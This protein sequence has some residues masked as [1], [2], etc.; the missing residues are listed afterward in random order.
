[1]SQ[2]SNG[3][4]GQDRAAAGQ[5]DAPASPA[6]EIPGAEGSLSL[7]FKSRPAGLNGSW[8]D[9]WVCFFL[10]MATWLVFGQTLRFEFVNYD[11]AVQ[12]YEVPQ[13]VNGLTL[14]GILWAFTHRH[15][16]HW[17]PLNT[18]S[19]MLDS[20]LYGLEAGGHHF[21]NVLLHATSA[22]FLF[23]VLRQ[24]TT[25]IWPSAFVAAV[26]AVH[27]LHVESVAWVSERKDVLSGFFF[28][29]TLWAYARY[30]QNQSRIKDRESAEAPLSEPS[31]PAPGLLIT[32]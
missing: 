5:S 30:V 2:E 26:F 21:T 29:L 28:M 10:V 31:L 22:I 17:I 32:V 18:I 7:A 14:K 16:G 8:A 9:P 4:A 27:P 20:Q 11:D 13:V 1:M 15:Y 6:G 3:K 24:M 19:H 12:V 23:L 25:A